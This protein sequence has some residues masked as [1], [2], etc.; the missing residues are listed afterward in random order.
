MG[1]QCEEHTCQWSTSQ[2]LKLGNL[3]LLRCLRCLAPAG[4]DAIHQGDMC[5]L[6]LINSGLFTPLSRP[7]QLYLHK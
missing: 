4:T 1:S 5:V 6:V 2:R 7:F 3:E